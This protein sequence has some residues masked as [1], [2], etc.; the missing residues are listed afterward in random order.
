M[1]SAALRRGACPQSYRMYCF[2]QIVAVW[3]QGSLPSAA[4]GQ[5]SRKW[6]PHPPAESPPSTCTSA[7]AVAN[8]APAKDGLRE[9][10]LASSLPQKSREDDGTRERSTSSFLVCQEWKE[11]VTREETN[12]VRIVSS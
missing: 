5:S 10:M 3:D 9:V 11:M 1:A 2:V 4:R 6:R 7:A 12:R 8:L